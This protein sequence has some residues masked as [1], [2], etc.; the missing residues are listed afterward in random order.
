VTINGNGKPARVVWVEYY[1]TGVATVRY[2][3]SVLHIP[4][5]YK[6]DFDLLTE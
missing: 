1:R 2:D 6:E 3:R 5:E 4:F